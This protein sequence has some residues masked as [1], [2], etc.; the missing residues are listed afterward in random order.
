MICRRRVVSALA[1]VALPL[2][3]TAAP[4]SGRD[5]IRPTLD[6]TDVRIEVHWMDSSAAIR[7]EARKYRVDLPRATF[8]SSR[9]YAGRH[10]GFSIL[11]KRNGE[12]VCLIFVRKPAH[13]DDDK[14]T[15]VGHELLHCLLGVYHR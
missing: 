11:G 10:E 4:A 1:I 7:L 13:V 14:T 8:G 15:A 5:V 2:L 6:F 12:R 3:T 9:L